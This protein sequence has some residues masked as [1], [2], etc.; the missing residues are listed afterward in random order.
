MGNVESQNGE[1]GFICSSTGHLSRKHISRSLRLSGKQPITRRTRHSSSAKQQHRNSEASTRSSST[2]SIPQSLAE[3]GLEPFDATDGLADFGINPHWTQRVA[4]TMRPESFQQDDDTLATPTPETSEA[5]TLAHDGGEDS[6]GEAESGERAFLQQTNDSSSFMKKRSKSADMWR[7]D[8]LE[9]SLSDL[10]QGHLTSTEEMVDGGEEEEEEEHFTRPRGS[11]GAAERASSLDHLCSHQSPGLR[12][13]RHRHDKAHRDVQHDRDA[14]AVLMSPGEDDSGAYGA[15]TLPCRRS[16]CLSEGLAGIRGVAPTPC[17][18]FQ[19]RRAQTTQDISTVLGEGSEYGD[20]G[21]DGVAAETDVDG[22]PLSRRCKAMSASFSVYSATE[23][24]VFNGSDSGSSSAGGAEGRGGVYENFRKE[25]DNQ[26]WAHQGRDCLEEAGSAVSDEQSSGTLSSAYPSDSATGCAHGT[27]RKAGALA[28]KNFLVHKKNKKVEPA[29]RRKWKHYWVSLKGCTLF[30]YESDGR[31]GIDH[32]SVPKHALWAE[33]SIVQAVPEHP[34]KDFVFC[35]SNSAG[36]AFLFQT[37]GQT[38]LENWI[39][40]IHSACAAALARQHHREDTVRLLRTEIRKLEQKIDMDEKMKKMGDMQLSTVTDAKK[41]KTILEQIFLWEQ[42]LERFHMDL[43]RCRCYLASLQGGEPPNPKRLLGFAS[44]P[45]KLAMGRLGIFSVSSFHALVSARTESSVKR[46][47][48]AV[49]RTFS[50][51]RSRFSSLWGLDTTSRRKSKGRPTISQ[52]FVEGM[53]PPRPPIEQTLEDTASEKSKDRENSVKSLPQ[54]TPDNDIWVPESLSPSWVCLPNDQPVLAIVQPGDTALEVLSSVCKK[55]KLDASGHY[56]RLKVGVNDNTLFYV[57]KPEEDVYDVLYKEIEICPKHTKVIQFDRA[58]SC[59]IGYGFCVAVL[60]EDGTQ[61]L[62]IT[63]VK[64]GGLASAKGLRAGDEILLLNSKPASAL[65]MDDMRAA[66]AHQALTLSVGAL[67]RLD[68]SMLCSLPPRRSDTEPGL[69]TDIFSQSQEDILDEVSGLTVE[70]SLDEGPL[71][72]PRSPGDQPEEKICAGAGQKSAEQV[73]TFCRSLHDVNAPDCQMSSSSSSSSSSLSPS[74]VS[75]LPPSSGTAAQRQLSHADKLRKVINELVETEKTYVKDLSC[76]IECYLTPLQKESFL[77]QDELDD[78]FGNLGEMVEFQVEFLRTLEDGIRLVPNLDRLE[79][80][81]QFKKVL[82]S[83]GG[84]FLYYAD[85]FKI[86]SAFC[87]S[88]TKVPK[89]LAKAK[90]DP[91][92]KAFLAE[93]NP[94]QQHS[95]TLESYLIKPIQRVLKYPLLLRELFS[96]TDPDSEEHYHLD[97][98]MTAMNKVASHINE[99]QKLHEEY[100]AVFDQ[101]IN[102]QTSHK[103]VAD[104]SMGDLLLHSTVVWINCPASLVKGKKDPELAAFVFKTAVVFVYKDSKHR[105]RVGGSHRAS[106]SDDK[107]PIRFRHM[108]ATDSLQ[109]RALTNSEDTAVCEIVHTRSESEGRPERTFQLC[110]SSPDSKKELLKAVHSILREKQRRQLL[111]TESLPLSQQYI[112]FGG[113]RLCALKG[114]RPTMNRAASAPSRTLA[115]RKLVRN[116][117]TIDTD[118]VFHGNNNTNQ[119]CDPSHHKSPQHAPLHPQ[120]PHSDDTD[121]WVEEQ[122]DLARY[123]DPAK[124]KETDILS[125]DD[126]YCKSVRAAAVAEPH[127]LQLGALTIHGGEGQYQ[128]L[129]GQVPTE[130]G[131]SQDDDAERLSRCATPTLKVAPLK[132][133]AAERAANQDHDV[134]WVRRDDYGQNSDVF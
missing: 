63:E 17:H 5:D 126:E 93:R 31:S 130:G 94:K 38:E 127:D 119:D 28:V 9:F 97:V 39:T 53:E 58:E 116:R 74:P 106:V 32:N 96:L 34:K 51:R 29:T 21:I 123:E 80:V 115:R 3:S 18:V 76:L 49:H 37:S 82:F 81:E 88:H 2:P 134:I 8:S 40:A 117:F 121:R 65:Q 110:C 109:V 77:T 102:D 100:G 4:M 50:K 112:P 101:L 45:T 87:A 85:R 36:D 73:S 30:L 12:G 60:D 26:V 6:A 83:L 48:Q 122:F 43:F 46:R 129:N 71:L 70:E 20:S 57:P 14:E 99:M 120:K 132:P 72:P 23:S 64:A 92:F 89:V 25:L 52:V 79:R 114:A 91:D 61:Q 67:P 59:S 55:H 42:N 56:V 104:L 16:H 1:S 111:K 108:I 118:L 22:E 33:N 13:Q 35:L 113:K 125:D 124:V 90:T 68:P 24:M 27:V 69:A 54:L 133:C 95:S 41:R 44:R 128:D 98:A 75:A 84:S 62:H 19:G 86:Y 78:L 7:E 11:A 15:F 10:S 47:S 131:V 103:K 107:D 105:K 66:F